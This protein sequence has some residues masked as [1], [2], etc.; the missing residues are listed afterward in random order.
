MSDITK[1]KQKSWTKVADGIYRHSNGTLYER[2]WIQ[3]KRT[4]RSL[5]TENLKH[6]KEELHRRRSGY[7]HESKETTMTV[8]EVLRR[9]KT[10][11]YPDKSKDHRPPLMAALEATNVEMLLQWWEKI[12]VDDVTPATCD[13]YFEWRKAKVKKGS[14]GKRTVDLDL[15]T[16]TNALSWAQRCELIKFHPLP[17]RPRYVKTSTIQH[18]REFMPS[19]ADEL[20][21]IAQIFLWGKKPKSQPLAWQMLVEAMTGIRT[22]EALGLEWDAKP[23]EPG[24]ISPDGKSLCIRRSKGQQNVNPFCE[25]HEG[26]RETIVA[27]KLWRSKLQTPCGPKWFNVSKDALS[28]ALFKKRK[29]I[30]RKITSHGMRAFFVLVRR[31]HGISDSQIAYELGHTTGGSTVESVYGGVPPHWLTGGGPK[32]SWVPA[33]A[34]AWEQETQGTTNKDS[35]SAT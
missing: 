10:D 20:H 29:E 26:L 7:K 13:K 33:G 14:T 28:H 22:E 35:K 16:L 27:Y 6:A 3:G 32:L 11:R 34:R 25:I 1:P 5:E 4:F 8:G 24:Y 18:C 30:G 17:K 9:Y 12:P 15:N 31:S 21:H 23:N 19:D 2:P